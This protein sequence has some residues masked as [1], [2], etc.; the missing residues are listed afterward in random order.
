M[1]KVLVEAR[2]VKTQPVRY[3]RESSGSERKCMIC[4]DNPINTILLPCG[5]Q[6]S[7]C[8]WVCECE[9]VCGWVKSQ[10]LLCKLSA[11]FLKGQLLALKK[12]DLMIQSL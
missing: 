10:F 3:S 9:W 12:M 1:R 8:V 4:M 7:I 11:Y 2:T 5:H 6:V